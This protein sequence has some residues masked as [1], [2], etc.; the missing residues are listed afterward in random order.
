MALTLLP[1]SILVLLGFVLFA[2]G[3]VTDY[4]GVAVIGGVIIVGVGAMMTTQGGLE[5]RAGQQETIVNESENKTVVEV[6]PTYQ[7]VQLPINLPLGFLTM[8]AGA[9]LAFQPLAENAP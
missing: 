8:L 7:Q 6:E 2:I 9:L 3:N 1:G 4:T 5:Y